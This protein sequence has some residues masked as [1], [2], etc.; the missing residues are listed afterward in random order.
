[1]LRGFSAQWPILPCVAIVVFVLYRF[2]V[3]RNKRTLPLPPGPPPLPLLG[4]VLQFPTQ[5]L[6]QGF[7]E[8]SEKYGDVVH[9][10]VLGRSIILIGSYEAACD[11]LE[12][13][14]AI[15][16]DRPPSAMVEL[17]DLDWVFVFKHYGPEWR[18]Y[19]RAMHSAFT[20]EAITRYWPVQLQTT[21][22]LLRNLLTSPAN[23]SAHI[24][25]S[26][27]ATVLRMVY[28]LDITPGDD[29]Y[30]QLIER[31]G[32][33]TA[34]I[35]TPGQHRVE[36][37]P[38]MRYLPSW[39][40][41]MGF[42]KQ[43]DAWKEECAAVRDSMYDS[44]KETMN[45]TG[46]KESILTMLTEKYAEEDLVKNMTATI[47]SSSADTTNAAAHA[48]ILALAMHPE[49][50]R[51][52]QAELDSVIGPDRLPEFSDRDALP[53]VRAIVKEVVRWHAVAPV[54]G[55]HR[56]TADDEYNGYFIPAKSII[57]PNQWAMSRDPAHYPNPDSFNPDRFLINGEFN[58]NVRD[59]ATFAFGFGRRICPGR[60]FAEA[61]LFIMCASILH[62]MNIIPALDENGVPKKLEMK[63]DGLAVEHP[64]PFECRF[65]ARNAH[66]KELVLASDA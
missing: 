46:V 36:A 7:R 65:T 26:F 47:Y 45:R 5:N 55:A 35:A 53:Y 17:T 23:F 39:F 38:S 30:Y 58:P 64:K 14:S 61:T 22:E 12:K 13:R 52:A 4:N 56:S 28:G 40:P 34:D 59:P 19:R 33:I 50:Q 16:S 6:G 27:A 1:M 10:R 31:L 41:G 9:L 32:S 29:R 44:A 37:F 20:A 57:I 42:K 11:I 49:V 51:K 54:G 2:L 15:Y 8:L 3:P 62:T 60:H 43:A 66:M 48:L 21:R 24:H 25:F 63:T 18:K